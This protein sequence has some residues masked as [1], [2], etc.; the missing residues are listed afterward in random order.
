MSFCVHA[1]GVCVVV[2]ALRF[3]TG[4]F[5]GTQADEPTSRGT[6]TGS[7]CGAVTAAHS[8]ADKRSNDGAGNTAANRGVLLRSCRR[9][10]TDRAIRVLT[11]C[12]VIGTKLIEAL[13]SA[14]Q[15]CSTRSGGD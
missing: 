3:I 9:L 1:L 6:Y 5:T 4:D 8:T 14:R 12:A 2:T 11:T 15:S 10:S 7:D 13:A